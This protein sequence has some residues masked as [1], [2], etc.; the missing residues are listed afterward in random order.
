MAVADQVRGDGTVL[1]AR[2]VLNPANLAR[3]DAAG[4]RLVIG[5][6]LTHIASRA[7]TSD[8][9][10]TWLVEGLA[11]YVGNLG[12]GLPVPATAAELA[13]EVRAGRVPAALPADAAFAGGSRLPQAY[14]QSWLACRLIADRA[15]Q[16]GLV[17]F[18]RAVARAAGTDPATAL[19]VGLRA[20][21]AHRRGR[22]HRRLAVLPGRRAAMSTRRLLVVT[23]D[24]PPRQG[25]IQSFVYELARR[26]PADQLAVYASDYPGSAAFDAD[27]DFPVRRHPGG[28][29]IPTPRARRRVLQARQD[30][31]STAVWFGASAPLG[32]LAAPLR[33]A[34]V[35]RLV[36]S[37]HGHEAGWAMLPVAGRRCAGSATRW[38]W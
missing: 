26:L 4:R 11:D 24:F 14:E 27:Q 37:T 15:G 31:G 34:G 28:L 5:H 17:R 7:V 38:T 8:Q 10:P 1:G 22:L 21:A 18:Y 23:N 16:A 3:L 29:L 36:A 6:E 33:R 20:G 2:I 9:M 30:F 35:R 25:G 32:L 13:A 12:S 19:A